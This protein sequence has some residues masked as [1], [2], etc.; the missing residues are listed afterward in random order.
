MRKRQ[1]WSEKE[2]TVQCRRYRTNVARNFLRR[3]QESQSGRFSRQN[4]SH[5][6]GDR[7]IACFDLNSPHAVLASRTLWAAFLLQPAVPC[8]QSKLHKPSALLFVPLGS[9]ASS[10]T[11]FW[12]SSSSAASDQKVQAEDLFKNVEN[13]CNSGWS[14]GVASR[15]CGY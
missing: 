1:C 4:S 12:R 11:A 5:F 15:C 6:S 9:H 8:D 3:R 14:Q 7:T 2:R 10:A 13:C